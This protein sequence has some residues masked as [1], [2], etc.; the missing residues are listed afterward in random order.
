[1]LKISGKA[2]SRPPW[3]NPSCTIDLSWYIID[4]K[5]AEPL[6]Y[7]HRPIADGVELFQVIRRHILEM[8]NH[9]P[10]A[11]DQSFTTLW[12]NNPEGQTFKVGDVIGF[13]NAHL[14]RHIKQIQKTREKHGI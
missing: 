6:D 1:M 12:S 8:V 9:L 11:W 3:G 5:C 2:A 10:G 13:Q 14:E 7:A 4:N